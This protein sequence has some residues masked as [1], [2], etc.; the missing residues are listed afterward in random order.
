MNFLHEINFIGII[1]TPQADAGIRDY[2]KKVLSHEMGLEIM[3]E[4]LNKM[5]MIDNNTKYNI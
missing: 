5:M 2:G 3:I 1:K 4:K